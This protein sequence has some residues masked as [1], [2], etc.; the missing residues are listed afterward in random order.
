MSV[1]AALLR[2]IGPATHGKMRPSALAERAAA[3]G[4]GRPLSYLATGNLIFASRKGAAAVRREIEAL[5]AGFGLAGLGVFIITTAEL[6]ALVAANPF[7]AA[8][9]ERPARLCLALFHAPCDWPAALLRPSSGARVAAIG[10]ALIIDY[11]PGEALPA[12]PIERLAGAPMTQRNWTTIL[13][14]LARMRAH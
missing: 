1:Y 4:L 2:A 7:A 3:A 6:E 14:V 10:R 5:V 8:A 9:W 13:G 12:L 11:G